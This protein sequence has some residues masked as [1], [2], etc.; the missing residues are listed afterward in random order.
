VR[1]GLN[2]VFL[3]PGESGGLETYSRELLL[4]LRA[5]APEVELVPFVGRE[6][7][8]ADGPWHHVGR[9]VVVS[10]RA[11]RRTEWVRGEQQ[12]LPFQARRAGI[13]LLHSVSNTGPGWGPTPRVT[14]V[15]DLIYLH[16]AGA[17]F[18]LNALGVRV[19][20]PL[21]AKRSRRVIAVSETTGRDLRERLGLPADRIDVIPNGVG[22]EARVAPLAEAATRALLDAGE[23]PVV[24]SAVAKRPHKNLSRLLDALALLPAPRPLLVLPGY[25]TQHEEELRARAARLGLAGDVRFLGWVDA[26]TLEGLYAA[27]AVFAFPSLYEGFGLPVLEAMARDVPVVCSNNG[28]LAEVAGDAALTFDPRSPSAIAA[29]LRRV[30]TDPAA[31]AALRAR[32]RA[33]VTQFSWARTARK[34]L[35]TYR[36]ALA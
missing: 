6:A 8:E 31:A 4:A 13:D 33:R 10:V 14:T 35:A 7:A 28:A 30:L 15:H 18:G 5:E 9:P 23:R 17:H 32:G 25:P 24:L 34:T 27:A 19:L 36:R 29:A 16:E 26:A 1:V 3:V 20:V 21:A 12:L 22:H 11:R 2:L